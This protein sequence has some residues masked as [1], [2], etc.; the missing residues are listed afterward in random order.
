M[1]RDTIRLSLGA[2][3]NPVRGLLHGSAALVFVVGMVGFLL[4][5]NPI[6]KVVAVIGDSTFGHSGITGLL[7]AAA[8]D[9]DMTVVI[10]DNSIFCVICYFKLN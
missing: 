8:D 6:N 10:M 3:Q 2:M 5:S 1:E 7:S 4:I 9:T